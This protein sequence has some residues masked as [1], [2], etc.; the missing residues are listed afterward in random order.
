[1]KKILS[2]LWFVGTIAA[3]LVAENGGGY[4]RVSLAM[5]F[6]VITLPLGLLAF[7]GTVFLSQYIEGPRAISWILFIAIGYFQWF[8]LL[9]KLYKLLDVK[10]NRSDN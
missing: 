4:D 2:V 5:F 3:V 10:K 6:T 9:P 8:Y 1:M 7:G